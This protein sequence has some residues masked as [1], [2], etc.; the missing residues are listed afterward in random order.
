MPTINPQAIAQIIQRATEYALHGKVKDTYQTL[1]RISEDTLKR[2]ESMGATMA[3]PQ[4]TEH[5]DKQSRHLL[6][7]RGQVMVA[8]INTGPPKRLEELCNRLNQLLEVDPEGIKSLTAGLIVTSST[9]VP[10]H[11]S[12]QCKDMGD[13]LYAYG[14][15]GVL[16]AI[17]GTSE[18]SLSAVHIER[19]GITHFRVLRTGE[20]N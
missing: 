13:G 4:E 1:L 8:G 15:I 18:Y 11:D 19:V 20:E 5:D 7:E 3:Q 14:I 17:Y 2:M 9:A 6:K 16:N 12:W 10:E